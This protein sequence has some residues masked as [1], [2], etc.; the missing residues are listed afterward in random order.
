MYVPSIAKTDSI[1]NVLV[2]GA[3]SSKDKEFDHKTSS[4]HATKASP[5]ELG[6]SEP[7]SQDTLGPDACRLKEHKCT[8]RFYIL[9]TMPSTT[10]LLHFSLSSSL[11]W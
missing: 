6:L 3:G 11:W 7:Q 5:C 9:N 4:H 10:I 1:Q 2:C 8:T